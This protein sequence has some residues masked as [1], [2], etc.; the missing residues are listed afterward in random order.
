MSKTTHHSK[1]YERYCEICEL[2][3]KSFNPTQ[4]INCQYFYQCAPNPTQGVGFYAN[5]DNQYNV[6]FISDAQ[7]TKS[8][9]SNV[10][11]GFK[12]LDSLEVMVV[13]G[14]LPTTPKTLDGEKVMTDGH[15]R[16][17]SACIYEGYSQ[18]LASLEH[19]S[20]L[21]DETIVTDAEGYYTIA[22]SKAGK[23]PSNATPECGVNW[24]PMSENGTG[25]G[26]TVEGKT[27]NVH[28]SA[29]IVRNMLP[30]PD[31][32]Q[33][34]QNVTQYSMA[35]HAQVMGEYNSSYFQVSKA[36]FEARG[37]N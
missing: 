33:A 23:R 21:N 15:L 7:K 37:C 1:S 31:F 36:D 22:I 30:S 16:Y 29:L 2:T 19:E 28:E 12:E 13:K 6:I 26:D 24:L 18:K 4:D 3:Q 32:D 17:W 35:H 11:D 9:G 8:D 5:F 27:N 10:Y 25:Y 34:L 20:C 14:K